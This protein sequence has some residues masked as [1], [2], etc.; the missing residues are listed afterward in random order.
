MRLRGLDRAPEC[1]IFLV[2][3]YYDLGS[4]FEASS[5]SHYMEDV[6]YHLCKIIELVASEYLFHSSEATKNANYSL[7]DSNQGAGRISL[8]NFMN[9]NS[10][11]E[12]SFLSNK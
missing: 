6:T 12:S 7:T 9:Q 10:L 8:D 1:S 3:L 4:P 11:L 5:L 2:Q